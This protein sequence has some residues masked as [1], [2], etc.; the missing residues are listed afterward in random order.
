MQALPNAKRVLILGG[1]DGLAVRELLKYKQLEGITLV[2][3]DPAMT[4]LFKSNEILLRLN[5]RALLSPKLHII[6][7]DAFTWVRENKGNYDCIIVDFPDPSNYSIG[8]LYTKTF[9]HELQ[10]LLADQGIIVV[11]ST[12]PYIARKSFWCIAHTLNDAQFT[13]IPYHAYVPSFGEWGYTMAMKRPLWRNGGTLPSGLK[14]VS[15]ASIKMML[16]FPPDMSEIPTGVNKLNDQVL[17]TY[18]EEEW[19]PYAH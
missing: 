19:S 10:H 12:S 6:N 13:T 5:Q 3:L 15:A 14:F 2:D 16:D 8:K 1:G 17:I 11:Q 18:F 7:S 4:A 9:Y